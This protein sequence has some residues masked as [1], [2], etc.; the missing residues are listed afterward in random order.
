MANGLDT[1]KQPLTFA[2][3]QVLLALL[4][5]QASRTC[6]YVFISL[7]ADIYGR[8]IFQVCEE[9]LS[10]SAVPDN[11][12]T[13]WNNEITGKV[14]QPPENIKV[15]HAEDLEPNSE[16]NVAK[17][18]Q[19]DEQATMRETYSEIMALDA[20]TIQV[21]QETILSQQSVIRSQRDMIR[22]L[23]DLI[24]AQEALIHD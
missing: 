2:Q 16:I 7:N 13:R 19:R 17:E 20:K 21:Q 24:I 10:Y 22:Q 14:L 3:R 5:L 18:I 4:V 9:S 12:T 1:T 23:Q 11:Q 6:S 15:Q 8:R